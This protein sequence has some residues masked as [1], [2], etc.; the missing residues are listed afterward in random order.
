MWGGGVS[1]LMLSQ[2]LPRTQIPYVQ[3]GWG[4]REMGVVSTFDAESENCLNPNSLCPVGVGDG[5]GV[6]T[7]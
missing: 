2:K 1:A 7:M 3:S 6:L 4:V 5:E